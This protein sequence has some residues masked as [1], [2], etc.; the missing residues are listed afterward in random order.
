VVAV[1]DARRDQV[2][3]QAFEDG[4]AVTDPQALRAEDAAALVGRHG[5]PTA[6]VGSGAP[7]LASA[8]PD[9]E[10][11][12]E[13]VPDPVAIGRLGATRGTPVKPLYLRAPDALLPA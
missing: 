9:A 10:L 2:Y 6:I 13:A 11:V 8:F 4:R 7:L 3:V 12:P 5:Q 1:V